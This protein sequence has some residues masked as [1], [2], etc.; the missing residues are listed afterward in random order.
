MFQYEDQKRLDQL[1][2]WSPKSRNTKKASKIVEASSQKDSTST[3]PIVEI[4]IIKEIPKLIS[5]KTNE[6][7][8]Y[9]S[10]KGPKSA[11][12]CPRASSTKVF[13]FF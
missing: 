7:K 10:T 11:N 5:E 12:S 2:K 8:G 4:E 6:Q 1:S 3:V 13:I 9:H